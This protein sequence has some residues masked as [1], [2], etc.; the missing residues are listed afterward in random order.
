MTSRT[1]HNMKADQT[2]VLDDAVLLLC[3]CITAGDPPSNHKRTRLA[4]ANVL[5]R[6]QLWVQH[7]KLMDWIA[8]VAVKRPKEKPL[9][10]REVIKPNTF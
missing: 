5:V 4:P 2:V 10:P 3:T 8:T 6:H 9:Q 1:H 7:L